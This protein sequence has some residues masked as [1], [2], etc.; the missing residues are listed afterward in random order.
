MFSPLQMGS[1][2]RGLPYHFQCSPDDPTDDVGV[3][4]VRMVIR[5]LHKV[6]EGVLVH[7][8]RE[9]VPLLVPVGHRWNHTK[10]S[11]EANL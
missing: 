9:L 5:Q 1:W 10:E 2:E 8:E 7:N 4:E 6:C 3:E 11:L